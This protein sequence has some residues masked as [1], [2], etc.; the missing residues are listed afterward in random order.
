MAN[1]LVGR[2]RGFRRV[3]SVIAVVAAVLLALGVAAAPVAAAQEE[4]G[5]LMT[6]DHL[7]IERGMA[8]NVTLNIFPASQRY[9]LLVRPVAAP[10]APAVAIF[11]ITV[12]A[13]GSGVVNIPTAGMPTGNYI[14]TI[15][16]PGLSGTL[17]R[18]AFGVIDPGTVG[19]RVVRVYPAS[20]V[21]YD[22]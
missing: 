4:S 15:D 10:D 5:P 14:V 7:V 18:T 6:V 17:V 11:P 3:S 8:V 1:A 22:S 20:P 16:G 12:D 2:R 13:V 21:E 19:P 9:T